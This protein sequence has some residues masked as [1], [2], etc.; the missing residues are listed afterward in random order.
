MTI[1]VFPVDAVSGAPTYTGQMLRQ[2]LSVFSGSAPAGRPLGCF[3]G[4]RRGTPANTVT[5]SSTT[6]TVRPHAGL[7]D[8][9]VPAAAGPYAYASDANVTGAVTA[10]NATNPRVDIV[11]AQLSDPAESDGSS[12]PSVQFLYLPGTAAA[13]PSAPATPVRSIVLAQINVPQVG[14]GSPS[15]SWVAP[16]LGRGFCQMGRSSTLSGG[17]PTSTTTAASSY[18]DGILGQSGDVAYIGGGIIQVGHDGPYRWSSGALWSATGG[19]AASHT[20]QSF[21]L[22]NG[23][24]PTH[25]E[26]KTSYPCPA[27]AMTSLSQKAGD[28]IMLSAGDQLQLAF[29]QNSTIGL[30]VM[31]TTFTVEEL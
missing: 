10:A 14:G 11:F 2:A 18:N 12:A 23:S 6:W 24:E 3:S 29:Y 27:G 17:V 31:P 9:E 4:V 20:K 1:T 28:V 21:V 16:V 19:G 25:A 22:V 30:Q 7:L 13:T 5:A 8:T 15:V 26:G